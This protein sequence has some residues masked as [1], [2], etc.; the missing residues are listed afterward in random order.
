MQG[1]DQG[2]VPEEV[3]LISTQLSGRYVSQAEV[4]WSKISNQKQ[5]PMP[6]IRHIIIDESL[7]AEH[8]EKYSNK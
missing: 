8:D 7:N 5:H 2:N 4:F 6:N 1:R 3:S